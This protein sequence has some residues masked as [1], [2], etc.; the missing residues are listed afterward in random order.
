MNTLA[1]VITSA[2][3]LSKTATALQ[4]IECALSHGVDVVGIFFYQDGVLHANNDINIASDEYQTVK[5]LEALHQHYALPLHLCATAAEKRG[6]TC[7]PNALNH[8][9]NPIFTVAGLGEL[10]E[11]SDKADRMVQF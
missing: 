3:Y 9:V 11:L 5:K 7:E 2:P 10:V 6:I 4:Y 8:G 1:V